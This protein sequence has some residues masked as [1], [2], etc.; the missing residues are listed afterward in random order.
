MTPG[1]AEIRRAADLIRGHVLETPC[2]LSRTLSEIT[3]AEVHLKFENLQFTASFKERGACNRLSLLTPEERRRGV[4]AMS[5]GNHAQGVAYH[6]QRLGIPAVIV[7]PRHTS[8]VKVERTRGFG[9]EVVT[10]GET[11]EAASEHAHALARERGLIFVHPYDDPAVIAGQGTLALEMLAAVPSMD[12]L[13]ISVGGGGLIGGVAAAARALRPDIEVIGVQ[14]RRFPAMYNAVKGASLPQGESTLADGM[15]V[16]RPGT[17]TRELISRFV[18]DVVLVDEGHLE[19][20]IVLL[21]EVEKTLVEGAGAAGLAALLAEP[22][23]FRGRRV[24]LVLC[25]GNIDPLLLSSIIGRGMVKAGRLVRLRVG[26][27]DV[28]GSLALI[29]GTVARASANIE[30]VHHQRAFS[31]LSAQHVEVEL[32]LQ[33]RGPAHVTEVVKALHAAGL[34]PETV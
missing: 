13:V 6:G 7:M 32:V 33:T 29:T 21:L 30:E 14:A 19:Q 3:G 18:S 8:A 28:P 34:S 25:G 27:R 16:G 2:V 5:A 10:H 22:E 20:A 11:L 1:I 9:A 31:S 24:G 12:T 4:V 15:A 26:A 23:R 17:I